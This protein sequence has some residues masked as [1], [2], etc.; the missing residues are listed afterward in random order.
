MLCVSVVADALHA[1]RQTLLVGVEG[2]VAIGHMGYNS[3]MK[4]RGRLASE[5][6]DREMDVGSLKSASR[7]N[8]VREAGDPLILAL[9]PRL[10]VGSG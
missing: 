9:T 10:L 5:D 4:K 8:R 7:M 6:G 3:F 1:L 2:C